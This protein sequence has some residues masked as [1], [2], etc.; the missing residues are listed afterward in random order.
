MQIA[1]YS[2]TRDRLE[3]TKHCFQTLKEKAGVQYDHYIIDNGSTDGTVEWLKEN[4]SQFKKVIY[5][6]ENLGIS[7]SSNQ[8]L[9]EI[10]KQDYDLIIKMDNDCDVV[11]ENILGQI[12][13]IYSDTKKFSPKYIL[14][15]RVEGI[16]NQPK[17][18]FY[19]QL[20]GRRIGM[21]SVVGGLFHIVPREV[22]QNYRYAEN[23][24]KAK[25]QDETFCG[26]AKS[27]GCEVGYIEGLVV[28]HYETT[29]GQAKRFPD[30]FKRKWNEEIT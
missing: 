6:S 1:V 12:A 7:K 3:Y 25:G 22:Y 27:N 29:E 19:I 28:N 8:A 2:L 15:P 26:W 9:D 30:Y 20:G 16:V 21:V 4:E 24:P 18:G 5:N 11:S 13:E 10:S 17:R 23:L 14:S